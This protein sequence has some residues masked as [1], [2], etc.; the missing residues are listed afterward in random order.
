MR[1]CAHVLKCSGSRAPFR[2]CAS[3]Q[4]GTVPPRV[5]ASVTSYYHNN[6]AS[7]IREEWQPF[8]DRTYVNHWEAAVFVIPLPPRLKARWH[9]DLQAAVE[10]CVGGGRGACGSQRQR[11]W[12]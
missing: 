2:A 9:A 8:A 7:L 1:A 5:W 12:L 11:R 3:E 6:R 4:V 10:R